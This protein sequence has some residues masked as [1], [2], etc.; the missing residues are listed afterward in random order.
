MALVVDVPVGTVDVATSRE[1]LSFDTQTQKE[2][3]EAFAAA[4]EGAK[5]QVSAKYE[6]QVGQ[7]AQLTYSASLTRAWRDILPRSAQLMMFDMMPK[8]CTPEQRAQHIKG[9]VGGSFVLDTKKNVISEF[10]FQSIARSKFIIDNVDAVRRRS[11][12]V[13]AGRY[14]SRMYVIPIEMD[15]KAAIAHMKKFMGVLDEQFVKVKDL[16]DNH[17]PRINTQRPKMSQK[18]SEISNGGMWVIRSRSSHTMPGTSSRDE[19]GIHMGLSDGII[20]ELLKDTDWKC[21]ITYLTDSE[22]DKI[23][24]PMA[25]S[26][27]KI[28]LDAALEKYKTLVAA[29]N[30]LSTM[31]QR[32]KQESVSWEAGAALVKH[33]APDLPK[34]VGAIVPS[35]VK[36]FIDS[37]LKIDYD[38]IV[39]QCEAELAEHRKL[40]PRLFNLKGFSM[41]DYIKT[42]DKE[43][44]AKEAKTS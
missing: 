38:G 21:K 15:Q 24:P 17:D 14:N 29:E 18:K 19:K 5:G 40:Y 22:F 35:Q 32:I 13:E 33:I 3:T 27:G 36:S 23:N 31:Q 39:E 9:N 30:K 10:P 25:Q 43:Y 2:V 37:N 6:A 16:P 4:W 42:Q 7:L 20:V 41:T 28:V 26:F 12:I 8:N 34:T 44:A 1:S 11:R